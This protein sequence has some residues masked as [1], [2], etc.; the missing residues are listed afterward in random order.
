M[1]GF[2]DGVRL[3]PAEWPMD[4]RD[5][6]PGDLRVLAPQGIGSDAPMI[7]TPWGG[8]AQ[9]S[10]NEFQPPHIDP[11]LNA[12]LAAPSGGTIYFGGDVPASSLAAALS[13]MGVR[14]NREY[15]AFAASRIDAPN[16]RCLDQLRFV[17]YAALKR[18]FGAVLGEVPLTQDLD[19]VEA[20]WAFTQAQKQK[21]DDAAIARTAGGDGDWANE[22]LGFG[23]HVEN[24]YHGVYR[25]WSRPWLMTK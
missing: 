15:A 25:I 6:R 22:R 14:A 13:L 20:A 8:A 23:F 11:R 1:D 4:C 10:I 3:L 24:S 19:V 5:P 7:A 17:P 18:L 21:W 16:E 9:R 12:P 2:P